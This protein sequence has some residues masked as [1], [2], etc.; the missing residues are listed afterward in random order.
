MQD[1]RCA[2]VFGVNRVMR[3]HALGDDVAA[4]AGEVDQLVEL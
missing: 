3:A 4:L 2:G 1:V